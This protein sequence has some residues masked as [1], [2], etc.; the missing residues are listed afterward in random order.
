MTIDAAELRR[1]LDYDP[2]SG[3][4]TRRVKSGNARAGDRAREGVHPGGYRVISV[5]GNRYLAHRLAWLHVHGRWPRHE[6]DHIDG[7]KANNR[8]G[9]LREATRSE[10]A[11]NVPWRR[12]Q[13]SRFP[14][15]SWDA[16]RG[17]WKAAIR[18]G[19]GERIYLGRFSR[20]E[21]AAAAY[22]EA[23]RRHQPF[24]S[25]RVWGPPGSDGLHS[26]WKV[27]S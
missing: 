27:A 24:A 20:E 25:A 21:D 3:T 18:I 11:Q 9:N 8:L 2:E 23:R 6:V 7:D 1:L 22:L 13:T 16:S 5:G 12:S 10:N 19:P 17:K 15:V 26:V 4:F 14:G